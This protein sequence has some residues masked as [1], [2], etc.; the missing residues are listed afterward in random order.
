MVLFLTPE[1]TEGTEKTKFGPMTLYEHL[2]Q[3]G[4]ADM[5]RKL[6]LGAVQRG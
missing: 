4:D 3:D 6:D 5:K 1:D 2:A